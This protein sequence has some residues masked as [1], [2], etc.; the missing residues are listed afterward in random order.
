MSPYARGATARNAHTQHAHPRCMHTTH[1]HAHNTRTHTRT[2]SAHTHVQT[3][4]TTR[5]HTDTWCPHTCADNTQHVHTHG[6]TL[7]CTGTH[8]SPHATHVTTGAQ[9]C[10]LGEPCCFC[11]CP[12]VLG[13]CAPGTL[14]R[15][16]PGRVSQARGT[17]Q[18]RPGA[19]AARQGSGP[20]LVGGNEL[21]A[22]RVWLGPPCLDPGQTSHSHILKSCQR[23]EV[24][25]IKCAEIYSLRAL[26]M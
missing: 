20:V 25:C 2:H 8:P 22:P 13:E 26:G 16:G 15:T 3:T 10:V 4:H 5:M 11:L 6:H 1:A 14:Q 24:R 7:S 18:L 9:M 17:A 23:L 19:R 21:S 12:R